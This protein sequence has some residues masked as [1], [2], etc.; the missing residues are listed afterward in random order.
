MRSPCLLRAIALTIVS[1]APACGVEA[2]ESSYTEIRPE[3]CSEP[4]P[5]IRSEYANRD[6]G[7]QEC[8]A[9]EGWRLLVLSSDANTWLELRRDGINW[10]A[11]KAIVYEHSFGLFPSV[12]GSPVI[13]W[14]RDAQGRI[15]ALIFR[16]VAQDRDDPDRHV[17]RLFVVRLASDVP[18]V[19]GRVATNAEAR[20]L[21]DGPAG[22]PKD[23]EG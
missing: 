2:A 1:A 17:S 9:L 10:S 18:C 5:A 14:R 23:T 8:P 13:E 12:A 21:A 15:R 7:V 3:A 19:I 4:L 6:I 11:E 22:C 16:V 20:A